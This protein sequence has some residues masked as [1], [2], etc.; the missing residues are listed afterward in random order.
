MPSGKV[1]DRITVV[2]AAA[3]GA[4]WFYLAPPSSPTM[5]AIV[6]GVSLVS[7]TLFSGLMLSPDLDLH[8]SIYNRWGPLKFIWLPYQ[9]LIPHRSPLSHSYLLGP[10]LRVVYFLFTGWLLL[11]LGTFIAAQFTTINRGDLTRQ[12][13]DGLLWLWKAHPLS[14]QYAAAGL[15]LG[16]FL[17][18]A[19]DTIV[20]GFK[21]RF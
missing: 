6:P 10:L 3:A 15:I 17:H 16:T 12:Y 14:V 1:H 13:T 18:V 8:S 21:R 4:A 19:A 9:K 2:G 11:R 20:T 7:M 5:E